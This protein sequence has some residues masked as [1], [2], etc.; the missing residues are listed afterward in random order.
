MEKN[1][2]FVLKYLTT[3][4]SHHSWFVKIS[5]VDKVPSRDQSSLNESAK[6][7]SDFEIEENHWYQSLTNCKYLN[8]ARVV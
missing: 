7:S 1:L 5:K 6:F 3:S 2:D 4:P 8:S